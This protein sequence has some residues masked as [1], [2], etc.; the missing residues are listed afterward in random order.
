MTTLKALVRLT[1]KLGALT[2]HAGKG[3]QIEEQ[4]LTAIVGSEGMTTTGG[5][6]KW[7]RVGRRQRTG[8]TVLE[9]YEPYTVSLPILLD[10]NY[11]GL[12]DIEHQVAI[13]EWFGGRG[14]LFQG[15]PGHPGL[16][17]PPLL[18]VS[19]ESELIPK[20][21]QSGRGREGE[22]YYVLDGIEYNMLGREW[23]PP[24]RRSIGETGTGRRQR[25][26]ATLT[27]IQYIGA[28]GDTSNSVANRV[29]L[30]QKQEHTFTTFIVR[31]G[32][33]TFKRIAKH[34]N[35][36]DPARIPDAAREIQKDNSRYGASVDKLLPHGA[37]IRVPESATS[38]RF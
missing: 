35:A 30:L 6:G 17:E 8:L 14:P 23:V 4:T 25:Q 13:L 31:G 26:S 28:Q 29:A 5:W 38:K 9:G 16:G 37:H 21:C 19:S 7:A 11:L 22:I 1:G 24:I 20:W 2:P 34:L 18:E 3:F 15:R 12:D 32:V 10:A 33:D 27:L 36:S